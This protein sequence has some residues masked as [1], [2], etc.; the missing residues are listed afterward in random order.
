[1]TMT[2]RSTISRLCSHVPHIDAETPSFWG[3]HPILPLL[4]AS[5]AIGGA[6]AVRFGERGARIANVDGAAP[7]WIAA[8]EGQHVLVL[9]LGTRTLDSDSILIE[10]DRRRRGC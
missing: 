10:L 7:N 3:D 4:R 9:D 5:A 1:M 6:V 8:M 2:I